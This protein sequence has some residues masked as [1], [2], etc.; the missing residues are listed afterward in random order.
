[1]KNMWRRIFALCVL[2]AV[3]AISCSGGGKSGTKYVLKYDRRKDTYFKVLDAHHVVI[4]R[5]EKAG[6]S[7]T[8]ARYRAKYDMRVWNA[9]RWGMRLEIV[10]N[11]WSMQIDDPDLLKQPGF[12]FLPGKTVFVDLSP[13]GEVSEMKGFEKLPEIDL[14]SGAEPVG[15]ARFKNEIRNLFPGMPESPV[16]RGD[17]W[18]VSRQFTEPV[19][20][21]EVLIKASYTYTVG[22]E[23]K[24][25]GRQCVQIDGTYTAEAAGRTSRN[26]VDYDLFL[27]GEGKQTVY[28]SQDLRMFVR[29]DE[30]SSLA[31][32]A[33]P[34]G[35]GEPTAIEHRRGR[36]VILTF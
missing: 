6:E 26:G 1:M 3:T 17:S 4:R 7:V 19:Y 5:I 15:Q 28:F 10:Y 32:D 11:D 16:R 27:T 25:S 31:G 24:K 33:R 36:T 22:E 18:T 13:I 8:D 29:L 34:D 23:V 21:G 9:G 30:E 2:I 20:G 14:G 35:P 12:E